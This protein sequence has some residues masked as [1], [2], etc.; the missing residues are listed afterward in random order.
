MTNKIIFVKSEGLQFLVR[1]YWIMIHEFH[2]LGPQLN[3]LL[4]VVVDSIL[5]NSC[6]D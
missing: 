1:P 6:A 3:D 5:V 4:I 2:L